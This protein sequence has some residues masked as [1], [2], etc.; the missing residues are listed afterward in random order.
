MKSYSKT[1][2]VVFTFLIF[3]FSVSGQKRN[4]DS[5]AISILDRMST[6]IGSINS[7]SLKLSTY[8]DIRNRSLGLV[9]HSSTHELFLHGPD[10]LFLSSE[11]DQGNRH[12]VFDGKTLTYYSESNNQYSIIQAPGSLIGMMDT[13]HNQYG[14]DFPAA[15]FFYPRFVEDLINESVNLKY[16]GITQMNGKD[17]FHI[18]G[19]T[20]DKSFQFWITKEVYYL[21]LKMVIVYTGREMNP[22]FETI[23]SEWKINPDIPDALFEF[24]APP[25]AKKVKMI[26]HKP[27]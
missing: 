12:I 6:L 2:L 21:P 13:M 23:F 11:G 27:L 7:V 26:L 25:N 9:K 3:S 4:I 14:I 8:Y 19:L 15:D 22:Q 17:C 1:V 16:L 5:T 10:K 20:P 18:A 24:S